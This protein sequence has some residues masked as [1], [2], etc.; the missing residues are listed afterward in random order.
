MTDKEFLSVQPWQSR[1]QKR[2][3]PDAVL[4]NPLHLIQRV[5]WK[6][7]SQEVR[8]TRRRQ[9]KKRT[10]SSQGAPVNIETAVFVDAFLYNHMARTRFPDHPQQ[11]MT[12]FVL[13][14]INAV[15]RAFFLLTFS[16]Y[17]Q[18]VLSSI[19]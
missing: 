1:R 15:I 13:A 9:R 11:E 17:Y 19:K 14:M 12:H 7:E 5:S 3:S 6:P 18:V 16:N 8:R 10:S 2:S 4:D